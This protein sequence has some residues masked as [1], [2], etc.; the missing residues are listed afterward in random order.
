MDL[1]YGIITEKMEPAQIAELDSNL[2]ALDVEP[3]PE[4]YVE[5]TR[6][7]GQTVVISASRLEELR[8]KKRLTVK[9]GKH[10][11]REG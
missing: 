4:H 9:V 3:E 2:E 10:T 11:T 5:H 1:A 7:D 6:A 8:K